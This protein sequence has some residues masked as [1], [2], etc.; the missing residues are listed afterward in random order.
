[1]CP[2]RRSLLNVAILIGLVVLSF[3][4]FA[5]GFLGVAFLFDEQF[6]GPLP[7]YIAGT[8]GALAAGL[9]WF[10]FWWF[11]KRRRQKWLGSSDICQR[12][13]YDLRAT[14]D[15]CPECGTPPADY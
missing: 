12:C 4:G 13:G 6:V 9:P 1:V 14:P 8:V 7:L 10:G 15:R 5:I 11:T 2:L 3:Y